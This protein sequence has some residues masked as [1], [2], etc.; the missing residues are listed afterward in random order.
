MYTLRVG[1]THTSCEI[2][3]LQFATMVQ[4][5]LKIIPMPH[6]VPRRSYLPYHIAVVKLADNKPSKM[7]KGWTGKRPL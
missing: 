3:K 5:K 4:D 1:I 7:M 2:F 6:Q